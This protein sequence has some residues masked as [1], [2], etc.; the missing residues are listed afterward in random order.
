MRTIATDLGIAYEVGHILRSDLYTADEAFLS[1]TAAE[2]VPIRSVD[3]REIGDPGP[4]TRQIQEIFFQAACGAR[5][6]ATRTGTSMSTT[7]PR[8][9]GRPGDGP[10]RRARRRPASRSSTRRCATASQFE[11]IVRHRRRQAARRRAARRPRRALHRGRLPGRQPQGRGV[12]RAGPHRAAPRTSTLVAFGST[13]RPAGK[14]DDGPD[15]REPRRRRRL[16]GVHRRQ[17]VGLPRHRGAADDPRRGRAP[18]CATPSPTSPSTTCRSSSTPSTSSTAT[19]AT[20]S[21]ALRVLEAAR[22]GRRRRAG[23]VRHERR[24]AAPRGRADRGRRRGVLRRDVTIGMPPTTTPG[25]PSPTPWPAVVAGVHP[26]PG[27]A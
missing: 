27:H 10:R 18:W 3:D 21:S 8:T 23:A 14:V 17:V 11:G 15:A 20:P 26:R 12:L 7:D 5:S 6:T 19:S 25:A 9:A 24:L 1:G 13:R 2:V 22:P 4:I 16:D